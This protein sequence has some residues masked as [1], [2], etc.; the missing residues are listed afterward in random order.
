[1]ARLG[2]GAQRRAGRDVISPDPGATESD[3]TV[4]ERVV[5]EKRKF[6][7]LPLVV[8]AVLVLLG[9]GLVWRYLL[10]PGVEPLHLI[11]ATD[12]AAT[13]APDAAT[14]A[15]AP[16]LDVRMPHPLDVHALG[17][18]DRALDATPNGR[19]ASRRGVLSED[20]VVLATALN[21]ALAGATTTGPGTF[22]DDLTKR[23]A[24]N[25]LESEVA[26][27]VDCLRKAGTLPSGFRSVLP[28]FLAQHPP[29]QTDA[30]AY[31]VTAL[32]IATRGADPASLSA[33]VRANGAF[34]KWRDGA[35]LLNPFFRDRTAAMA[36]LERQKP[37]DRLVLAWKRYQ[38][39][40]PKTA[41]IEVT[42]GERREGVLVL[43]VRVGAGVTTEAL[44]PFTGT[45]APGE[46][47]LQYPGA[48]DEPLVFVGPP[49]VRAW[50]GPLR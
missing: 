27:A 46:I 15:Q 26:A 9:G 38:A 35:G 44:R 39:A 48:P 16:P 3:P 21:D 50:A 45:V 41:A 10:A 32:A 31:D 20:F 24:E 17:E 36:A 6:P 19:F 33:L 2:P 29:F 30:P 40:A 8:S 1:V 28:T 5:T 4:L 49:E 14:V 23:I 34:G 11:K 37:D 43:K 22:S 12:A 42:G 47:E 13:S 25:R 7:K 18:C